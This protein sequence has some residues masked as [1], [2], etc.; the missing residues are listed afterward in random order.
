MKKNLI[1]STVFVAIVAVSCL[2]G[3]KSIQA[4]NNE[5][6]SLLIDNV[7]ALCKPDEGYTGYAKDYETGRGMYVTEIIGTVSADVKIGMRL[8]NE[9]ALALTGSIKAEMVDEW[10]MTC[11]P[12]MGCYTLCNDVDW[13]A[14]S[15]S[16]ELV[17]GC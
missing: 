5:G 17:R 13:Q 7:E 11:M 2:G 15:K 3:I 8:T 16:D 14:G 10:R 9:M 12:N 6:S 4:F 1:K